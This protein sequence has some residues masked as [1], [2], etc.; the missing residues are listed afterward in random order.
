MIPNGTLYALFSEHANAQKDR[1]VIMAPGLPDATYGALLTCVDACR[2]AL[3]TNGIGRNSRLGLLITDRAMNAVAHLV[4]VST[5]VSVPLNSTMAPAELL[6]TIEDMRIDGILIGGELPQPI[7]DAVEQ[8]GVTI[9]A[10][11]SIGAAGLFEISS[12]NSLDTADT[13]LPE[14]DDVA[15]LLY[16]SGTTSKPKI[17]PQKQS[18][19]FATISKDR[20]SITVGPTDRSLNLLPL[21]HT[22]GLNA[23]FLTPLLNGGSVAVVEF[24]PGTLQKAVEFYRPTWFTLV[25]SMHMTVLARLGN[26]EGVFKDSTLRYARSSS[27]KLAITL[28][29]RLE[30]A[31][32]IP[33]VESYGAT[34]I[35]GA[36]N[37]GLTADEN[38]SGSVGRP[39]HSG[40]KV[41]NDEGVEVAVDERGEI[42]V[43]GPTVITG[44]ENNPQA[45][46]E[47]FRDGY[48]RTGDEGYFDEDGFLYV[49][50]RLR[51]V[52]SRGG[53]KFSLSE[54]D[55][56]IL[57]L[58][59]IA[60]GSAF[61][62]SHQ[63]LG[64]EVHAAV[65]LVEGSDLTPAK[66]RAALASHL[67]WGKIP[68]RILV[69]PDL[70]K[71][72]TGKILRDELADL[73]VSETR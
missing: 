68:K 65:V 20:G 24:D 9:V 50:G 59:G 26:A 71:N 60:E 57:K 8:S 17:V 42:C 23:E 53:E 13:S 63:N 25:P 38:R 44:Y 47:S 32:G 54:I 6:A 49:T 62:I 39:L 33:V 5:C 3:H 70:P 69:L 19:R 1:P 45:N 43:T 66:V 35:S 14:T 34:E 31:Y 2:A 30:R 29:E 46:V 36:A 67:S 52:I 12:G 22:Q 11:S 18:N 10:L 55:E 72:S 28:R 16:T 51:D 40:V 15:V 73:L 61:S 27:A 41:T 4:A 58:D 48:Y 21:N 64:H 7:L 37:T 56:A